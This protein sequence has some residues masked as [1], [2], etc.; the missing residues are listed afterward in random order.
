MHVQANSSICKYTP[1]LFKLVIGLKMNVQR[2]NS[3]LGFY[4][5]KKPHWVY[6]G[7]LLGKA[8]RSGAG[9]YP[10]QVSNPTIQNETSQKSNLYKLTV[11][12][13]QAIRRIIG[14]RWN[15]VREQHI[16]NK[17]LRGLL[18]NTNQYIPNIDA[19]HQ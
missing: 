4:I 3:V 17:E 14:I 18:S 2:T 5:C 7:I 10:I 12:H 6:T 11:F 13:H 8:V 16:K 1:Y 9:S 15:Q 19:F